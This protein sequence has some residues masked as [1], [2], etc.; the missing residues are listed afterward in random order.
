MMR[1]L[2]TSETDLARQVSSLTDALAKFQKEVGKG[3]VVAEAVTR[4]LSDQAKQHQALLRALKDI[5]KD[6]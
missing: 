2:Q 6:R 1:A 5:E 4:A 3:H